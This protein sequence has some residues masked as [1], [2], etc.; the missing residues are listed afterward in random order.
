M[1]K[2]KNLMNLKKWVESTGN[3]MMNLKFGKF[4]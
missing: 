3:Q 2:I 1:T 4:I